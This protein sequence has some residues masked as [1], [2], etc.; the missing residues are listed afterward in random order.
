MYS[1]DKMNEIA[2]K[3]RLAML[4]LAAEYGHT[5][6]TVEAQN[7]FVRACGEFR[8]ATDK[9]F[10]AAVDYMNRGGMM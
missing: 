5:Q 2:N 1:K 9:N 6:P 10:K 8:Q 7:K 4:A 3:D